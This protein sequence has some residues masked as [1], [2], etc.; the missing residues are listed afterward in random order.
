MKHNG[1]N[2]RGFFL[3]CL[4]AQA[5]WL[6]SAIV[7]LV[8]FS[9]IAYSTADPDSII[10]PMALCALYISSAI[11]GIGA[12]RLS[13]DGIASGALSGLFTALIV[14]LLSLLPFPSS[15]ME[16]S[17]SLLFNV[18]VIPASMAGAVIGHKRKKSPGKKH[19]VSKIKKR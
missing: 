8:I 7:L 6:I 11:G 13:G 18:L 17:K 15:G 1:E 12:V 19:P 14:F 10:A 4:L 3:S 5:V 9:I 2:K 16:I